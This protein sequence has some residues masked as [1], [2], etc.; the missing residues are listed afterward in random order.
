MVLSDA[1]E[2]YEPRIFVRGNPVA[3]GRPRAAAVPPRPGRRPAP[4][5]RPR[6]RP[7]RPG[8][9]HHRRRQSAHQPGHRQPGLDAPLRRAAGL[10][11]QRLRHP[12]HA[13]P[14]TPSCSTTWPPG[15]MQEGWSLK[16]LH[17]LI[18]LSSTYQQASFDRP[19]CRKVDPE[20]RLLWRFNRRRLD[21]EAMRD[22]LLVRLGPARRRDGRPAGGRGRRSQDHAAGRSTAWSIARACPPS[23]APSTS[24]APT[25]RPSAGPGRPCPSR[26]SSA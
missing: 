5:V 14:L 22:T 26:P 20:N 11:P 15:F 7:A 19:D 2:L 6:Q 17:R 25:S 9:G 16:A 3:A 13:R 23:S 21:L 4:A 10:D 12:Q 18:V 8:P 1:A 24:P